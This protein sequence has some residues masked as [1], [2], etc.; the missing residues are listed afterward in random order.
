MLQKTLTVD[1]VQRFKKHTNNISSN[2]ETL[3]IIFC[4]DL[5]N[6]IKDKIIKKEVQYTNLDAL[7][8]AIINIDDNWYERILKNKFEKNIC[9]KADTH[10]DESI[11]RWG[12]YY[13]KEQNYNN[14]IVFMKIN[15][16]EHHKEK[17]FKN[18]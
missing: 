1:Y 7:I 17:N 2:D 15:S 18:E 16:I 5:K 10:Y 6:S 13:R 11:K 9:D 4:K 8:F 14:E 3:I 12:D